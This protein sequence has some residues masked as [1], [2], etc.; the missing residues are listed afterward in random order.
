M[1]GAHRFG[2][3]EIAT[4]FRP[5]GLPPGFFVPTRVVPGGSGGPPG[6]NEPPGGLDP[7]WDCIEVIKRCPVPRH[8]WAQ[9][10]SEKTYIERECRELPSGQPGFATKDECERSPCVTDKCRYV[11]WWTLPPGQQQQPPP[12]VGPITPGGVGPKTGQGGGPLT[13]KPT[14]Y[15]CVQKKAKNC[16]GESSVDEVCEC[17]KCD[18]VWRT[19]TNERAAGWECDP[20]ANSIPC[21]ESGL[22][23]GVCL[24]PVSTSNPEAC[25]TTTCVG[26]KCPLP[27]PKYKCVEKNRKLCEDVIGAGPGGDPGGGTGEG[28]VGTGAIYSIDR[29]CQPC[30]NPPEK[31]EAPYCIF[32]E[33]CVQS[34]GISTCVNQDCPKGWGPVGGGASPARAPSRRYRCIET[35][36]RSCGVGYVGNYITRFC[37]ECL[38]YKFPGETV[39]RCFSPKGALVNAHEFPF[40]SLQEC[41]DAC[42]NER[43]NPIG[44]TNAYECECKSLEHCATYNQETGRSVFS[45]SCNCIPCKCVTLKGVTE[46]KNS[47]G[48]ICTKSLA[49]CQS[50]C[51]D[52]PC[53]SQ[54]RG[55][56]SANEMRT[57]VTPLAI[58]EPKKVKKINIKE[59]ADQK[60]K[61]VGDITYY[62]KSI[63]DQHYNFSSIGFRKTSPD[64]F[65]LV[66]NVK[67]L[68]IFNN[69]VS[70]IVKYFIDNVGNSNSWDERYVNELLND[71]NNKYLIE[72]LNN[73]L[74]VQFSTMA[75]STGLKI[76]PNFLYNGIKRLLM[77]GDLDY[78]DPAAYSVMFTN[79][80][81][82]VEYDKSSADSN[83]REKI[84]LGIIADAASYADPSRYLDISDRDYIFNSPVLLSD[85]KAYIPVDVGDGTTTNLELLD[86]GL[87][88]SLI[89]ST[90]NYVEQGPGQRSYISVDM[91]TDSGALQEIPLEFSTDLFNTYFTP[92]EALSRA[93]QLLLNKDSL[94][95]LEVSSIAGQSE[96]DTNFAASFSSNVMY[97]ALDLETISSDTGINSVFV[98]HLECS[99]NLMTDVDEIRDHS[100]KA[101][102]SVTEVSLDAVE[103][104]IRSYLNDSETFKLR[105]EN[106]DFTAFSDNKTPLDGERIARGIIPHA[107][108]I[109]FATG[110]KYNPYHLKSVIQNVSKNPDGN[111]IFAR[112]CELVPNA[113]IYPE[114]YALKQESTYIQSGTFGIGAEARQGGNFDLDR[115]FFSYEPSAKH[116]F[117]SVYYSASDVGYVSS[118]PVSS[119]PILRKVVQLIKDTLMAKY[120][121]KDYITWW[122][123]FSRLTLEEYAKARWEIPNSVWELL[124][125]GSLFA[126]PKIKN[127]LSSDSS[128]TGLIEDIDSDITD[129]VIISESSRQG[130]SRFLESGDID[131]IEEDLF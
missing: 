48:E 44:V 1:H 5:A 106:I 70:P 27:E 126:G 100:I 99:Y 65:P 87:P 33:G 122:D 68:N 81:D 19:K 54:G 46:C 61:E 29:E 101:G 114:K 43:C 53:P 120:T 39:E 125:D 59:L 69:K 31:A 45:Q 12:S 35:N 20:K 124:E 42:K 84:A 121:Y 112:S 71:T 55:V 11:P 18:C 117:S 79:S 95:K 37:E 131:I 73:G 67:Y 36:R 25:D 75:Y 98:N 22:A 7:E 78:F 88:C 130:R 24:F 76:N 107:V 92:T 77:I 13:G 26:A 50:S 74:V 104:P 89:D 113:D 94:M 82:I 38:C 30:N 17:E 110:S 9:L 40:A 10:E 52:R 8:G 66:N 47:K 93:V 80:K 119:T 102:T 23:T 105:L 57:Q 111:Y 32:M 108:I 97:F 127:I 4:G 2:C 86:A 60:Y 34:G 128:N 103:D 118:I 72:S 85:M 6:G 51:N 96:I 64:G 21:S 3:G 16:V 28:F 15:T 90:N 109:F 56:I 123:V 49:E 91:V 129:I 14:M 115:T 58:T 83:L 116:S 62:T 63:F 41:K